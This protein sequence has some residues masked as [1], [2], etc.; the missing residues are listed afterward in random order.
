MALQ[1]LT[2]VVGPAEVDGLIGR[3]DLDEAGDLDGILAEADRVLD[4]LRP[5][6]A[7]EYLQ[8]NRQQGGE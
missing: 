6:D 5:I 2:R 1:E 8:Q 3:V 4:G 7:E